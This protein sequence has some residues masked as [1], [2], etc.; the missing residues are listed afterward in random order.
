MVDML[1][2]YCTILLDALN[3]WCGWSLSSS[4][5][6]EMGITHMLYSSCTAVLLPDRPPGVTVAVRF[7]ERHPQ[8]RGMPH[9]DVTY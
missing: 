3:I 6:A 4:M 7:A 5:K 9:G 8:S 1:S 2:L